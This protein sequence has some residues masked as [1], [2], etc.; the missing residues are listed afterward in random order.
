MRNAARRTQVLP[1][2]THSAPTSTQAVR[3][4]AQGTEAELCATI[5]REN[6]LEVPNNVDPVIE[7]LSQ[8]SAG[9]RVGLTAEERVRLISFRRDTI[10]SGDELWLAKALNNAVMTAPP[11]KV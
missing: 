10:A 3:R 5:L 7:L 8:M 1:A 9:K 6:D 11:P 4:D 2:L